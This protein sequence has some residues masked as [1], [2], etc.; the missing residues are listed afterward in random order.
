MTL[1]NRITLVRLALVPVFAACLTSYTRDQPW[2]RY[3]A[4]GIYVTAAVSDAID[5]FVARAYNQKTKL[6]AVMDPLADKLLINIGFVFL[7]VNPHFETRVPLWFPV[8]ILSRD[9]LIVLG[10]YLLNRYFGPLRV[11]PRITGK[12]T[13]VLQCACI[14]A[15][16]LELEI[17]YTILT[18]TIVMTTASFFDYMYAGVKQ[19]SE[20]DET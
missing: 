19:A 7:A 3:L 20:E 15:V 5:G 6:G 1:A 2:I 8:V 17:A 10:A 16:L 13:T 12:A 14:I 9:V 11:R 18:L 4:L